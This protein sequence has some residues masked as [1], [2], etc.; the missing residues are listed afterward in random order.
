MITP[1]AVCALL[2]ALVAAFDVNEAWF[3]AW[4]AAATA[5]APGYVW[6]GITNLAST[7]GAFALMTPLLS[8]R[9]RWLA[10]TLLAAPAATLYTHGLKQFFA[11]PRPAAVLASDQFT[12]VGL[13]LRTDSF[14]SGH[15]LTAFVVAGIIV[16]CA[17]PA[18][19]RQ[20]AWVVLAAAILM[21]FS[22]VAV[23]AH[24]PLDLFAGAAGGWVSAVIGVRWSARWRFW[25]RLRGIQFMG[26]LMIVV[27]ALLAFEDLG[28][29]EGLWMQYLL[30][31][32]GMAGAVFALVRPMTCKVPA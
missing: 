9:P 12:I 4:N 29:P 6:A 23:G 32:W 20:W 15:S 25:E 11:E 31:V 24:W 8:W 7:L 1:A 13:P 18:V 21:C 19:R 3:I 30:V 5:I 14:P 22:R 26:G 17:S 28:Y 10:A 27:A 2:G 16:L